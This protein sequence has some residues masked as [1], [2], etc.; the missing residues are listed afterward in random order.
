MATIAIPIGF[1]TRKARAVP[2]AVIPPI[3]A[4]I[5]S[6]RVPRTVTSHATA[7]ATRRIFATRSGFL[8]AQS[9]IE[10]IIG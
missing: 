5:A 1:A 10:L 6:P 9:T 3:M 2:S 8:L 7:P 4:G